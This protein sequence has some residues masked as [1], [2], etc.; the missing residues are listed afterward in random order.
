[1][2]T[3]R[4]GDEELL[5]RLIAFDTTSHRSNLELVDLVADYV[6]R[7]G[8]RITRHQAPA[9]ESDRGEPD[10]R[11]ANLVVEIGPA[12][13]PESRAGLVL[14]GHTDV[15]PALEPDWRSDPFELTER[16]DLLY[17]RGSADMKGFLALA[18]NLAV[19]LSPD[20]MRAPLVLIFT[21]DEEVGTLGAR[22]F[23]ETWPLGECPL[24]RRAIIGEPTEL[25]VIRVH[26]GHLKV[27]VTL[28]GEGAHSAYPH[29]GINAIEPAA[30]LIEGLRS[31]RLEL[32]AERL[33][34]SVWFPEVPFQSLNVATIHGGSAVNIVP[35]R[36][37]VG[38]GVRLL[39][40][41]DVT[42]LLDRIRTTV[43]SSLGEFRY[44]L[45][46]L[47]LSP[48]MELPEASTLFSELSASCGSSDSTS[49]EPPAVAF[50]TDAGWFQELDMECLL[51]GPG[52]I[53]VAHRANEF[54]PRADLV[55]AGDALRAFTQQLLL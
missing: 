47:S 18:T 43:A 42:A 30:A 8:V 28:L 12:T 7:P 55:V 48:P 6:D 25:K 11:K 15:V 9:S 40:G 38:F 21:Y 36:C 35:D 24:P 14:S 52:S 44:R 13:D 39:P 46:I 29:L 1:M 37:A 54:V 32:E 41:V 45:E 50:A 49:A 31:L 53:K 16:D 27:Q 5:A 51:Y 20:R 4:L 3:S 22:H 19:E 2:A 33:P 17:A 34:S 10:V 23:R 26:K